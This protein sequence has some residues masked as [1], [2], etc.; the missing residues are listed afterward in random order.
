LPFA[1]SASTSG[2][3]SP[4]II[5]VSIARAEIVFRLDTTD[6]NLMPASVR[7]EALLFEWR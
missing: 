4:T 2:S 1:R 3:V 6:D 7:H 5:A